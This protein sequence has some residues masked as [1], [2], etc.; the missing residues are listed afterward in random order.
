MAKCERMYPNDPNIKSQ[1]ITIINTSLFD[2]NNKAEGFTA[3]ENDS[4][5]W[6]DFPEWQ[7]INP[8]VPQQKVCYLK[9][10]VE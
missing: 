5:L 6:T 8:V 3:V 4:I 10:L 2:S 9:E 7:I 1:N